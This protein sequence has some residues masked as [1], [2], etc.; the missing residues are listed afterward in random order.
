[1]LAVTSPPQEP[2]ELQEHI[3]STYFAT[4]LWLAIVAIALPIVLSVGGWLW[5]GLEL[6]GSLSQYYHATMSERSMRNW[7]V[8]ALFVLSALLYLYKGFS[9]TENRLLNV[10]GIATLLVALVPTQKD[11]G[12]NCSLLTL[13]G[14]SAITAFAC[15]GIV[16]WRC[17]S[18]T[19]KLVRDEK[20]RR[21]YARTYRL[22]ATALFLSPVAA[23][24]LTQIL[25]RQATLI[26]FTETLGMAAFA[27]YWAAKSMELQR[28]RADYLALE[29]AMEAVPKGAV[30]GRPGASAPL[31]AAAGERS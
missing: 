17:A 15:I 8:G 16:A 22:L 3:A 4:R 12:E 29:G 21:R 19:L 9:A 7:F 20:A 13:H 10:A 30:V 28:T 24:A 26:F 5:A 14:V 18:D 27:T 25:G 2:T 23:F 6:Q 11:C 31:A 1:M